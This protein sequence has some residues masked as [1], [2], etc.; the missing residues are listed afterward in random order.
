MSV[1]ATF[2]DCKE[3][4]RVATAHGTARPIRG[5]AVGL[6]LIRNG[7]SV[8]RPFQATSHLGS[9]RSARSSSMR[10]GQEFKGSGRSR[11]HVSWCNH[12]PTACDPRPFS[13][14]QRWSGGTAAMISCGCRPSINLGAGRRHFYTIDLLDTRSASSIG[15]CP[16]FFHLELGACAVLARCLRE[17]ARAQFGLQWFSRRLITQQL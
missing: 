7:S 13:Q 5:P 8:V 9:T 11:M 6:K 12:A 17:L 14:T 15:G 16:I 3:L 4:S 1:F 10:P 2:A